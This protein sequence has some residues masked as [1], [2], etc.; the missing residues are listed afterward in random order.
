MHH[1]TNVSEEVMTPMTPMSHA[2]CE[3]CPH[4]EE[5]KHLKAIMIKE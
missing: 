2:D 1:D 3:H 4:H 5:K